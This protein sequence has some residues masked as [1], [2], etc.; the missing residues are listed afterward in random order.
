MPQRTEYLL[1]NCDKLRTFHLSPR[2]VPKFGSP[3]RNVRATYACHHARCI[4]LLCALYP[5]PCALYPPTYALYPNT[6]RAVPTTM[7]TV[8]RHRNRVHW[9]KKFSPCVPRISDHLPVVSRLLWLHLYAVRRT[10]CDVRNP[11]S[12]KKQKSSS[13]GSPTG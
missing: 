5:P 4:P 13:S 6:M 2:N 3:S 10:V 12:S 8:P 1:C 7:C 11:R 9:W